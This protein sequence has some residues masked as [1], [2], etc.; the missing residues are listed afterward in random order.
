M[1]LSQVHQ[2]LGLKKRDLLLLLNH[3]RTILKVNKLQRVAH[4]TLKTELYRMSGLHHWQL[5]SILPTVRMGQFIRKFNDLWVVMNTI[6]VYYIKPCQL[7]FTLII[8]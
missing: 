2:M 5:H 3:V 4:L 8:R 1:L 7:K 6:P